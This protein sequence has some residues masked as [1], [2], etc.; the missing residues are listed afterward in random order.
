[1]RRAGDVIPEIVGPVLSKRPKSAAHVEDAE[2]LPLVRHAAR[3]PRGRGRPPVPEQGRLP[4]PGTGVAV[5]LRGRG[6]PWTSRASATR[7]SGRSWRRGWCRTP[8]TS[9]RSRPSSSS[10]STGSRRS[11]SRTCCTQIEGSKDRPLW[12]LLVGLNIRH[13]GTHVAQLLATAFGSID[14]LAAASVDEI[15]DVP[16][17]G[18]EIAA[19][20]REWFDD[21][22][23]LALI[24]RLRTAGRADGRRAGRGATAGGA[25]HGPDDR[26]HRHDADA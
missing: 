23:N 5:P 3:P 9:T 15:D 10:S 12:R 13:V 16:G 21:P 26:P 8:P 7:R 2:D 20:V 11:R 24:E 17:I 14:A 25:A 6:A 19:S 18:P 4:E 22:E 1:M